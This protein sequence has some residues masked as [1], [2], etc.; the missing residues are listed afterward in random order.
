VLDSKCAAAQ[1]GFVFIGHGE[2][3]VIYFS[4]PPRRIL[5][6]SSP[7]PRFERHSVDCRRPNY[8]GSMTNFHDLEMTSITGEQVSFDQF[9]GNLALV[10]NVASA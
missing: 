10:V 8:V 3:N 6:A 7:H 9:K 2:A 1:A 5:A 4:T